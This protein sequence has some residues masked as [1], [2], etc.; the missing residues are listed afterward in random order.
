MKQK[1]NYIDAMIKTMNGTYD[2]EI[3]SRMAIINKKK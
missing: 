1:K 3:M 2:P